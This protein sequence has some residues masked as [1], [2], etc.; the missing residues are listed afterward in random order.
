MKFVFSTCLAFLSVA[1]FG[2]TDAPELPP[3]VIT[4]INP[5]SVP[6][7]R[8]KA[9]KRLSVNS[10]DH[11][12]LIGSGLGSRMNHFGHFETEIFLRFAAEE[13]TIRNFS[14]EGNTPAFRPH[15]AR[16]KEEQYAFPGGKELLPPAFQVN[17][18]PNGHFETPDQ[19]TILT[20]V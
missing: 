20:D 7:E 3:G 16:M 1:T 6:F 8:T 13:L 11:I 10:D 17:S 14:D 18:R 15:S 12:A 19:T 2:Q 9:P 5:E 4:P